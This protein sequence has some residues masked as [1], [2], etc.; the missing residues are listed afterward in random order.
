MTD[1]DGAGTSGAE[2]KDK[3][4]NTSFP[5]CPSEPV[6]TWLK[7][8]TDLGDEGEVTVT[9]TVILLPHKNS[10]IKVKGKDNIY[11]NTS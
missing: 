9:H 4:R 11:N 6:F 3:G 10:K 7:A 1:V 5:Q 8:D 2:R